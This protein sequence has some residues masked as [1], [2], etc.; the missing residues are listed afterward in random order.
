MKFDGDP[1]PVILK[2]TLHTQVPVEDWN[3]RI[4][5]A[6]AYR[7]ADRFGWC[8]LIY[9]HLTTETPGKRTPYTTSPLH[10]FTS[11]P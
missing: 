7:L 10:Y 6:T 1:L 9:G 4:E 8:E 3:L 2:A 5:L 11:L